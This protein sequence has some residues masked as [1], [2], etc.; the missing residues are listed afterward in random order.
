MLCLFFIKEIQKPNKEPV[1]LKK[2]LSSCIEVIKE[3]VIIRYLLMGVFVTGCILTTVETYWQP[4]FTD[5]ADKKYEPLLGVLS[6]VGFGVSI[7]GN[8]TI[9]KLKT[10]SFKLR[11]YFI[12]KMIFGITVI[13]FA[14][15]NSILGFFI[16]Y[17][18]VYFTLGITDIT[19]SILINRNIPSQKRASLL[20]FLSFTMQTGCFIA[21]GITGIL[22]QFIAINGVW[23][24]FG[25]VIVI[26]F[27]IC[28]LF[29]NRKN[30]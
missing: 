27:V 21:C 20:S 10:N 8:L 16:L 23:I 29:Y 7:L 5:I 13:I 2:H 9:H 22:L 3:S 15:Q 18:I 25:L 14:L 17:G 26:L 6:F 4:V 1:S 11:I 30:I 24:I 28:C 19:E 12:F